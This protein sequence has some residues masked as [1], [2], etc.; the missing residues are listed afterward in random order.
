MANE[1]IKGVFIEYGADTTQFKKGQKQVN[2]DLAINKKSAAVLEKQ[3]L[4]TFDK[5]N[6]KPL[7]Q[8]LAKTEDALVACENKA[9]ALEKQM[10][11]V[12]DVDSTEYKRLELAL[13]NVNLEATKLEKNQK[14]IQKNINAINSEN[15]EDLTQEYKNA[16]KAAGELEDASGF[17]FGGAM[18]S[19]GDF[20]TSMKG[21][22]ETALKVPGPMKAAAA[23]V[24]VF[25]G[26]AVGA[27]KNTQM[28]NS[29]MVDLAPTA[30]AAGVELEV[31]AEAA[32]E[33]YVATGDLEGAI[34]ATNTAMGIYGESINTTAGLA[35]GSAS[36]Y[37]IM[38]NGILDAADASK[39]GASAQ[40][41]FGASM[42]EANAAILAGEELMAKYPGQVDDI[43]DSFKEFGD[44]M[45]GIGI[46]LNEFFTIMNAGME[47]GAKNTDE[48]VN[49]INEM[50]L[51]VIEMS[52]ETV[53]AFEAVGISAV[54]AQEMIANEEGSE[55]FAETIFGLNAMTNETEQATAAAEI[56]GTMGEEFIIPMLQKEGDELTQLETTYRLNAEATSQ[57]TKLMAGELLPAL[58]TVALA[59]GINAN[60]MSNLIL[61]YQ[62]GGFAALNLKEKTVALAAG[63]LTNGA[64]MGITAEQTS[65]MKDKMIIL[66]SETATLKEKMDA[67]NGSALQF[68][69]SEVLTEE[70]TEQVTVA[71][72]AHRK[73][74]EEL[75]TSLTELGGAE[76][77]LTKQTWD[78]YGSQITAATGMDEAAFASANYYDKVSALSEANVISRNEAHALT[79]ELNILA[80]EN[81]TT[82]QKTEALKDMMKILVENGYTP[83]IKAIQTM[84]PLITE[85]N[86]GLDGS[87]IASNEL[88]GEFAGM[89]RALDPTTGKLKDFIRMN[90]DSL[91]A[92]EKARKKGRELENQI[93]GTGD[94][95]NYAAGEIDDLNDALT[96]NSQLPPPQSAPAASSSAFVLPNFIAPTPG[97]S[98]NGVNPVN[99]T[100]GGNT[101]N[102]TDITIEIDATGMD[103]NEV[104]DAISVKLDGLFFTAGRLM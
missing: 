67:L 60:Q 86:T 70:Q 18:E 81:S 78:Q 95:A 100:G 92:M 90:E 36:I 5:D 99:Q 72:D 12:E 58:K 77:Y 33:L 47:L 74:A 89:G 82:A 59:T 75:K 79:S 91:T 56:F 80:N 37:M 20:D 65:A 29:I 51:S 85:M 49:S 98:T 76:G 68:L 43:G 104:A 14:D 46:D 16:A 19:V 35:A 11:L 31:A 83:N 3:F 24:A 27:H 45:A 25:A 42:L 34:E 44:M 17:D 52:D 94:A 48:I 84:A 15:L 50:Q 63:V 57:L 28:L 6:V 32:N 41:D 102:K 26:A 66:T 1:A 53:A 96:T 22:L 61:K 2:A 54:E 64:A 73:K 101:V 93:Y 21:L 97:V 40:D 7:E 23:G 10:D 38:Q 4:Q 62:E 55:L 71:M 88:T 8:A 87:T 9:F 39:I 13:F 30:E 103:A 69:F